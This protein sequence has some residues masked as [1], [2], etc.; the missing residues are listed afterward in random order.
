MNNKTNPR[1]PWQ[2]HFSLEPRGFAHRL[3]AV[4]WILFFDGECGFCSSS[5]RRVFR[6]DRRG[7]ISFAP[8][9]GKLAASLGFSSHAAKDGGTMVLLREA[10][11]RIFTHSDSWIELGAALGGPWRICALFRLVP[12][13]LRDWVYRTVAANRYRLPAG[14]LLCEVPDPAL[15][16]RLRD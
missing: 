6:L 7:R 9:Q 14:P 15:R 12:K 16:N 1:P 10:D 4:G 8:L 11:G 3:H 2:G 13:P 5:V